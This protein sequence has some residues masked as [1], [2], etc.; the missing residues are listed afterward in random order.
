MVRTSAIG[1]VSARPGAE[2]AAAL[3][4][5]LRRPNAPDWALSALSAPVP[6]RVPAI[7]SA[8]SG[9]D[10]ALAGQLVA[11][12]ARMGTAEATS[13]I[14]D[15]MFLP[16][17]PARKVAATTLGALRTARAIEILRRA[18][19]SDPDAEVRRIAALLLPG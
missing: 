7:V 3:I 11:A 19:A 2:T 9:A 18:A 12:L 4:E 14:V 15:M 10:D 17:V 5:L 6:G 1:F 8:L 13:A 16:A